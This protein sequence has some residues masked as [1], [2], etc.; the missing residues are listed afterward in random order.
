VWRRGTL[1]TEVERLLAPEAKT[2]VDVHRGGEMVKTM[3]E[4]LDQALVRRQIGAY[5]INSL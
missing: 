2:F 4:E 1:L 5:K 3:G